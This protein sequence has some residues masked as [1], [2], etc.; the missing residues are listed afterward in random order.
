MPAPAR[1]R[2]RAAAASSGVLRPKDI[3]GGRN[4]REV[5]RELVRDG[6]LVRVGHGLYERAGAPVSENI[7]LAE[8]ARRLPNGVV[9]LLS[10]LSFHGLTTENP[11]EVWLAVAH[12]GR[13][14]IGRP[15]IRVVRM[16]GPAFGH[17]IEERVVDGVP[18]RIYSVAKTIA[19]CFKFR[20]RIGIEVAT[21]ALREGWRKRA[22]EMGDLW[23]VAE[24]CRVR[25]VIQPYVEML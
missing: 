12:K 16:T 10:A 9:C 8:V 7:S 3:Q 25:K 19:D 5:I 21:A 13:L 6:E 14:Q 17:G 18:V 1:D 15:A 20:N 4:P 24:A 11:H 23:D 22:F 2:I